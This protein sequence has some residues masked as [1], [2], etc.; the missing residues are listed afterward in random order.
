M[1]KL[2][3]LILVFLTIGWTSVGNQYVGRQFFNLFN[4]TDG[5]GKVTVTNNVI[6]LTNGDRDE[7]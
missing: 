7:D 5:P 2:L 6:T 1:R 3:L 4:E